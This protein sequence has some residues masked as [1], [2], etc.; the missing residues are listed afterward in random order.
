MSAA[1]VRRLALGALLVGV[2]LTTSATAAPRVA[3]ARNLSL[4]LVGEVTNTPAGASPA[5]SAQFG[6]ISYLLG[7]PIFK[8]EPENE[9][10]ALFT[11]Y[12]EANTVRVVS[13]GPLRVVTRVG[14]M[15]IYRNPSGNGTFDDPSSFRQGTAVLV[16]PFRQQV[17]VDTLSSTFSTH[18]LDRITMTKPFPA[19]NHA[20]QLGVVGVRFETVLA[21]HLNM[22]GPPSG[23]F[24]GYTFTQP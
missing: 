12:I 13:D 22:P 24:A 19:A 11:F 16:A 8:G 15:T 18:N 10:T 9:A 1:H 7:L 17:V 14:T 21:G 5:T 23:Y 4:E 6:Y 2:A 3:I 20:L